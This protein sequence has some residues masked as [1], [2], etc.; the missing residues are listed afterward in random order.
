MPTPKPKSDEDILGVEY[1]WLASDAAGHVAFFS[2][3]GGGY[4]PSEFLRDTEAHDRAIDAILE[5]GPSTKSLFSPQLPPALKNTWRMM[6][7]RGLFAFDS[8]AHRAPYLLAAAPENPIQIDDLPK[9]AS[10]VVRLLNFPS[11]RF[12]ELKVVPKELL[13]PSDPGN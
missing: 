3:A 10:E 12:S 11:L 13:K 8:D 5:T 7:E 4:A 2:T 1:D 6:A 9:N